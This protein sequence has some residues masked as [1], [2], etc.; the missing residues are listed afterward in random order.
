[1]VVYNV[2]LQLSCRIVDKP[3]TKTEKKNARHS[4]ECKQKRFREKQYGSFW[5]PNDQR[6]HSVTVFIKLFSIILIRIN[7]NTWEMGICGWK[8]AL[9][10][11]K[12]DFSIFSLPCSPDVDAHNCFNS[13]A[14]K[15]AI[16]REKNWD[17]LIKWPDV[18][19]YRLKTRCAYVFVSVSVYSPI[20]NDV[21]RAE[22][23]ITII[24][25]HTCAHH[26]ALRFPF[27]AFYL[28]TGFNLYTHRMHIAVDVLC[29]EMNRY[30]YF[31]LIAQH[32]CMH[33]LNE[34]HRNRPSQRR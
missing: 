18:V 22:I 21:Q 28:F 2:Q 13:N 11:Y 24:S 4:I 9:S 33:A 14:M 16:G 26:S 34:I 17:C 30:K 25:L 6:N 31:D 8:C 19:N 15:A 1:M 20:D 7:R 29:M 10:L 32:A 27:D 12:S 23:T 5:Q 3:Q